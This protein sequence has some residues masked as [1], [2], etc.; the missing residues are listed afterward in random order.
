[1]DSGAKSTVTYCDDLYL[2]KKQ[3][4]GYFTVQGAIIDG[5]YRLLLTMS[6][7]SES[8]SNL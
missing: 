5:N 3:G 1:M 7:A 4:T 6:I 8:K 2:K